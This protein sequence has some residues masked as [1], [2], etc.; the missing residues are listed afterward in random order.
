MT[1]P[2]AATAPIKPVSVWEDFVDIFY[3][4]GAVF[5]RRRDGRWGLAFLV[6]SVLAIALLFA[7]R[8]MLQPMLDA[9][10]VEQAAAMRA[11]PNMSP[12]QREKMASTITGASDS[13]WLLAPLMIVLPLAVLIGGLVLWMVSKLFGSV[14]SL[15]QSM[16]IAT[17]SN[18]PR[19]IVGL[20][21]LGAFFALGTSGVGDP[22]QQGLSPAALL[23]EDSSVY[24][25]AMASRFELG[26]IWVTVLMGIGVYKVG[27]LSKGSA[28]GVAIIMWILATLAV[29]G[30]A[31]R[32]AP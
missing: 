18:F 1:T 32:Q 22:Y 29:I 26:A 7:S 4:P 12:E 9:Q 3:A 2:A 14:Q 28:I 15:G 16:M 31:V 21:T 8:P 6:Y 19:L 17:Y 25:K 5:E 13:P 11:D 20:L 23:P 24:L 30:S 27:R 10:L